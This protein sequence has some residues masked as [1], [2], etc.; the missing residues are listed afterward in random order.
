MSAREPPLRCRVYDPPHLMTYAEVAE[1]LRVHPRT[2]RDMAD[3]GRLR[4]V[5]LGP[6]TLRVTAHSVTVLIEE[7]AEPDEGR[8]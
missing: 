2:V 8:G 1:T 7:S 4:K 3:S 6:Q 5:P